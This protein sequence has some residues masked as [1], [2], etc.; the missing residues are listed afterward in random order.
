[1][2]R[3]ELHQRSRYHYVRYGKI[4]ILVGAVRRPDLV[5]RYLRG[6]MP[7]EFDLEEVSRFVKSESPVIVEAGAFDGRDTARFARKWPT[8]H[9]FAF[10]PLPVL[11]DQVRHNTRELTNVT[12]IQQA[13]GVD[14]STSVDL[15]T[16]D[17][18]E[19][20]HGSS[21][22]LNPADHL[23][24][25]P[26]IA[27][28]ARVTVPAITLNNWH[29]AAGSPKVD[30]LWLDLQGA[31][32]RVLDRGHEVLLNTQTIHIEVSRRPLY[33]GGA[34]H[35]EVR[36]YLESFGFTQKSVRVPVRSGNAIFA[37]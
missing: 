10:E 21:S 31:E 6:K 35:R 18:T 17:E 3:E 26:E 4:E 27:F 2:V 33:E 20:V 7:S 1:M 8:G 24:V 22:L 11:A 32:L 25:A 15:F 36:S 29:L 12:V 14:D 16:F 37:R 28:G 19:D 13:L 9:V 5:V 30:L 34:T 23:S